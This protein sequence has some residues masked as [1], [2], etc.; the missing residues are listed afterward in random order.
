MSIDTTSPTLIARVRDPAD[1][2]AWA[3]FEA[4]Y[5]ELIVR[6]CRRRGLAFFDADDVR[7]VVMMRLVRA[8]RD[9]QYDATH[10]RFRGFLG[11]IVVNEIAR[12]MARPNTSPT[13]VY[14]LDDAEVVDVRST[15]V[16]ATWEREWIEHHLRLAMRRLRE[17][18][19]PQSLQVF[20]RLLA[21]ES[22]AEVARE[23]AMT[24]EAVHKVKQRIRDRLHRLIAQQIRDEDGPHE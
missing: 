6:Y 11:R 18:H 20:D 7:Q 12:F 24:T 10:G 22:V 15:A 9:H 4:R 8:L 16:D 13:G 2:A 23:F 19:D 1:S 17:A 21:G 3:E 5:G 14:L